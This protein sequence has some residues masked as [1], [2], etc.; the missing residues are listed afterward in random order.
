[1]AFGEEY[2]LKIDPGLFPT[3]I[4]MIPLIDNLSGYSKCL[5]II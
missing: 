1:M 5:F 4:V 2:L 3:Y